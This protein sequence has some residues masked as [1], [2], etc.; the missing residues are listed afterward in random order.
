MDTKI[1]QHQL[2]TII[3]Y[4]YRWKIFELHLNDTFISSD[5]TASSRKKHLRPFGTTEFKEPIYLLVAS[6]STAERVDARTEDVERL[7]S[8]Q[9]VSHNLQ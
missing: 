5:H 3:Y 1:Q 9:L 4:K 6:I 7:L 8:M 2:D